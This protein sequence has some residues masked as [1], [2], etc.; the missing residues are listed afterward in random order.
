MLYAITTTSSTASTTTTT[1][2]TTT[3]D[4]NATTYTTV[5]PMLLLQQ[6]LTSATWFPL[7][8]GQE[9]NTPASARD[10][11][12][13]YNKTDDNITISVMV[14]I[15]VVVVAKLNCNCSYSNSFATSTR[16]IKKIP[17]GR[18]NFHPISSTEFI[19]R[20]YYIWY[21]THKRR[22]YVF[23]WTV[24]F[25]EIY[26]LSHPVRMRRGTFMMST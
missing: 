3:A 12:Y 22:K 18:R 4:V 13:N 1:A 2:H 25:L 5:L 14:I 15:V 23:N 9:G 7:A 21:A 11:C 26:I 8:W 17:Y 24:I 6:L 10:Y 20:M 16:I 19:R